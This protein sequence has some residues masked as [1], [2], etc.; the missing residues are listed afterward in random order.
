MYVTSW[1]DVKA[2]PYLGNE[3]YR[4][5]SLVLQTP[6]AVYLPVSSN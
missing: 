5:M 4:K 3:F 1:C 6:V 2:A